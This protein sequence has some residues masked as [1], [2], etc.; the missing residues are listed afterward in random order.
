MAR[1][2]SLPNPAQ[3]HSLPNGTTLRAVA[4]TARK[5]PASPQARR[6]DAAT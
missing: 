3:R 4:Q 2:L 6:P 1:L 5:V